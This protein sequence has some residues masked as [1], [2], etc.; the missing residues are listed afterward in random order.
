MSV[1]CGLEHKMK[2]DNFI[3]IKEQC[4]NVYKTRAVL[5]KL[6]RKATKEKVEAIIGFKL[7]VVNGPTE[8]LA[9]SCHSLSFDK[10][11]YGV[12]AIIYALRKISCYKQKAR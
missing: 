11:L 10:C 5:G 6:Q 1:Q 12:A 2:H 7:D 3:K 8:L 9:I 4:D